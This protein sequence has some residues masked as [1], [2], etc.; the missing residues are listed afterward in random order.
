[1]RLVDLNPRWSG[2][3]GPIFDG[4][5]FD[6]PHCKVQR[7]GITFTPP[8]DPNGLWNKIVQPTYFDRNVWQ[9]GFGDTFET[10]TITPSVNAKIDVAGHWHGYITN[11]EVT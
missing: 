1:M 6:C 9:R 4:V 3:S 2:L 10:L 11:G 5:T 8:I 7:I